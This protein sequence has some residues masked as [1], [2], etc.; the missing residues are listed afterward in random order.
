MQPLAKEVA[1]QVPDLEFAVRNGVLAIR[2]HREGRLGKIVARC[3]GHEGTEAFDHEMSWLFAHPMTMVDDEYLVNALLRGVTVGTSAEGKALIA[4]ARAMGLVVKGNDKLFV[5]C[6]NGPCD[7]LIHVSLHWQCNETIWCVRE[8]R[9]VRID[10]ISVP[11]LRNYF[12]DD[13]KET[14]DATLADPRIM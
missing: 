14:I 1:T 7:K 2:P 3:I 4:G 13:V 6:A 11:I 12:G 9:Q 10:P 5:P 8:L